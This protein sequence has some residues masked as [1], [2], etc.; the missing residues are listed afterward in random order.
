MTSAAAAADRRYLAHLW[1]DQAQFLGV[2]K[3][4]VALTGRAGGGCTT[5]TMR[6]ESDASCCC[7]K[8]MPSPPGRYANFSVCAGPP[9]VLPNAPQNRT[10]CAAARQYT[11]PG[12]SPTTT[13]SIW[14]CGSAVSVR[15]LLGLGPA[16]YFG[17][18]PR[19][20]GGSNAT[21]YDG[22][23]ASL[24]DPKVRRAGR[25]AGGGAYM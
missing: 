2:Y 15:E 8:E 3:Q 22:M 24:F 20:S 25:G 7:I 9:A 16:Y 6:G 11:K 4:G 10:A 12:S 1:S 13:S 5:A 23:W 19:A 21:K 18:T 14:Q 17:I